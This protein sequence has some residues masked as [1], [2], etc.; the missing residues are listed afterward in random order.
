[1]AL[2]GGQGKRSK[3]LRVRGLQADASA[4]PG[5]GWQEQGRQDLHG[6]SRSCLHLPLPGP[7]APIDLKGSAR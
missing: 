5:R 1:M 7:V 2:S 6:S 3:K 4:F